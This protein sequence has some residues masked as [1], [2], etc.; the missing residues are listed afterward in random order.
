M[1]FPKARAVLVDTSRNGAVVAQ[2]PAESGKR[3][4]KRKIRDRIGWLWP[5]EHALRE[6]VRAEQR[7]WSEMFRLHD[8]SRAKKTDRWLMDGLSNAL[9]SHNK[10][11]NGFLRRI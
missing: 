4:T 6:Y 10:G 5:A 2:W 1:A 9:R 7:C 3:W 8:K 11:C